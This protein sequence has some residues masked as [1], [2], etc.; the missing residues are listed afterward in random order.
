[1]AFSPDGRT[2]ASG[3]ADAT[4]RLWPILSPDLAR[5][6]EQVD[7]LTNLRVSLSGQVD[8]P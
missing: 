3:S 5:L 1:M 4:I 8:F 7:A 6:R 2:L